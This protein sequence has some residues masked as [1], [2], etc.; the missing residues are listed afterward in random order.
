MVYTSRVLV[1]ILILIVPRNTLCGTVVDIPS[2]DGKIVPKH[3]VGM[4][5]CKN[6]H[7][8]CCVMPETYTGTFRLSSQLAQQL[9]LTDSVNRPGRPATAVVF[10]ASKIRDA[11]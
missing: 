8:N 7:S 4:S 3:V 5:K 2:E 9:Y 10:W 1:F 11:L 6:V